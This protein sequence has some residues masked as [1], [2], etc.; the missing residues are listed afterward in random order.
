MGAG[1]RETPKVIGQKINKNPRASNRGQAYSHEFDRGDHVA[2]MDHEGI[3]GNRVNLV[4]A[5][6]A[7][8]TYPP[9]PIPI[10]NQKT[11][12]LASRFILINQFRGF[13]TFFFG[14]GHEVAA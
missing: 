9:S 2:L 8:I 1:T 12:Y 13:Y 4:Q 3:Y 5:A 10:S 6:K 14:F 7:A 11:P